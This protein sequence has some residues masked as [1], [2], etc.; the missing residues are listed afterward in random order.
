VVAISLGGWGVGAG[1]GV[2]AKY[3]KISKFSNWS[4][5][6]A[7]TKKNVAAH[8]NGGYGFCLLSDEMFS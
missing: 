1:A 7:T 6:A 8:S 3:N 5:P 4:F 2:V